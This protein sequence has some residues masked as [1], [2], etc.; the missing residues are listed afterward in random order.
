VKPADPLDRSNPAM[1]EMAVSPPAPVPRV[2]GR[3]GSPAGAADAA[4]AAAAIDERALVARARGGDEEAFRMLVDLHRDR[5]YGLALRITRSRED[6]E[7][8]AQEGFVRAWLALPRF[9]G[10]SSFGTWLHRI[11]ARRALDR[12]VARRAREGRETA[13]EDAGELASPASATPRDALL[14]RRL[15]RLVDRLSGPQRAVVTLFYTED[16][17]VEEIAA[18]LG[19]PENTVKT[20]L[21]RARAALREAWLRESRGGEPA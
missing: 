17:P 7:D 8:A 18:A 3:A 21:S 16:R 12:S 11:V 20:H 6:A 2:P 4:R 13:L 14:A 5:A 10:E 9:R 1:D 19:M 15:E